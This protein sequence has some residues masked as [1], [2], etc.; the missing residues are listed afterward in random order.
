[1]KV[2]FG[3]VCG[4]VAVLSG[5]TVLPV[6]A[7]RATGGSDRASDAVR[8]GQTEFNDSQILGVTDA[9]SGGQVEQANVALTR[10]K[11]EP[12]KTLAQKI[13]KDHSDTRQKGMEVAKQLGISVTP[14]ETSA[15]VQKNSAEKVMKLEK[16]DAADFDRTY[17]KSQIDEHED[18]LKLINKQLLPKASAPQVK[19]L[20]TRMRDSV[21]QNLSMAHSTLDNLKKK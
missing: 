7:A 15:E 18:T 6:S 17:L 20:L 9:D 16:A 8:E 2:H 13:S 19:A 4:A 21:Q 11:A 3:K 1:M 14:S 12:V 5:L 10:A